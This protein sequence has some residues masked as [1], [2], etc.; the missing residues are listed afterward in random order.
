MSRACG[1]T[2][3]SATMACAKGGRGTYDAC[4]E[5]NHECAVFGVPRTIDDDVPILD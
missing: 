4:L 1:S 5:V 3:S 2:L